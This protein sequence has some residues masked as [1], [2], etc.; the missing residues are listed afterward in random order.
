ML[1]S[2]FLRRVFFSEFDDCAIMTE[3]KNPQK[4]VLSCSA[5]FE[6][7]RSLLLNICH[8][9]IDAS[10]LYPAGAQASN[11]P[12]KFSKLHDDTQLLLLAHTSVVF[13]HIKM[14]VFNM[15]K[16][17]VT[18]DLFF[19]VFFNKSFIKICFVCSSLRNS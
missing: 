3:C 12:V 15:C 6:F 2:L 7:R 1:F 14:C 16:N 13:Y 4:K 18:F 8:W 9:C 5:I 11:N 17:T 19:F 10:C